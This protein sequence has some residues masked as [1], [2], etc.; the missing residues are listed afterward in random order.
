MAGKAAAAMEELLESGLIGVQEPQPKR[1]RAAPAENDNDGGAGLR[2]HLMDRYKHGKLTARSLCTIAWHATRAGAKGIEDLALDPSSSNAAAHVRRA[3]GARAKSTFYWF[4]LPLWD[5]KEEERLLFSFPICLPHEEFASLYKLSPSD[6]HVEECEDVFDLPPQYYTHE[7]YQEH[8]HMACPIGYFSD[9]VPHTNRDSFFAY[10]WSNS[11]TGKRHLI[12]SVRKKDVCQCGCKGHCTMGGLL[13]VIAWSFAVLAR[14]EHPEVRH[15]GTPFAEDDHRLL[16]RGTPLAQG[17]VGALV[18][19][20]AD[21]L[22]IVQACGFKTWQNIDSPCFACMTN[23]DALFSFP[24]SMDS[25]DDSWQDRTAASHQAAIMASIRKRMVNTEE[26]MVQLREAMSCDGGFGGLALDKD[27]PALDLQKGFRLMEEGPVT[28]IH[29]LKDLALPAVLTFF[30]SKGAAVLNHVCP[31]LISVPGF[32]IEHIALDAMHILDLGVTQYLVGAVLARLVSNNFVGSTARY[33]ERRNLDNIIGLRRRMKTYY[34][35]TTRERGRMTEVGRLTLPMLSMGTKKK[36]DGT[37]TKSH[38]RL[39]AKAAETRHLLPMLSQIIA[40]NPGKM[41]A[42]AVHLTI[43][44]R[45]MNLFYRTMHDS[46]RQMSPDALRVLESSMSR[47]LTHWT[48]W[49]GHVV[50]KHHMAWHLAQ[51]A[52]RHG[53]PRYY[54]TYADEGE[55]RV[56]SSVAKSLHGSNSF[57]I[58]FLQKVLP[59]V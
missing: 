44:V 54:W 41:G 39:K 12:C 23:R 35:N 48:A 49:G 38:P 17:R 59:E 1:P 29:N 47:F 52:R 2:R 14:G 8:Q 33:K 36:K 15:D 40:E 13:R 55:N 56:M 4:D 27:Y 16:L 7:V 22:E 26:E 32:S 5:H 50:F 46:P 10:Y 18:E 11:L 6:F 51:R 30:D 58:T 9:A 24:A 25:A 34:L 20:R 57:Y 31:L 37:S 3:V 42:G 45:E 28:D 53:N 19:M 43:C 21:L